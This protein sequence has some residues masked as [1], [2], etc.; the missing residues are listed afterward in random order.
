M[1]NEQLIKDHLT[2]SYTKGW[3]EGNDSNIL[4]YFYIRINPKQNLD[5]NVP[6]SINV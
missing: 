1:L 6:E 5:N 2:F 3:T 4:T